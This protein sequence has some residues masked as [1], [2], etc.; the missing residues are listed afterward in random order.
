M[1]PKKRGRKRKAVE[2]TSD[3]VDFEET[4]YTWK[5]PINNPLTFFKMVVA[6]GKYHFPTHHVHNAL[7]TPFIEH[8]PNSKLKGWVLGVRATHKI[9]GFYRLTI[10]DAETKA[11]TY[12]TRSD[13]WPDFQSTLRSMFKGDGF[14]YD[15]KRFIKKPPL[16]QQIL[17]VEFIMV[18]PPNKIVV[19]SADKHHSLSGDLQTVLHTGK[20]SDV[21]ILL[22]DGTRLTCHTLILFA[23]SNVLATMFN[24][25]F[26][27]SL[28][29]EV[30][31]VNWTPAVVRHFINFMY[32][33]YCTFNIDDAG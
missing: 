11:R 25:A 26:Q 9:N 28:D 19:T 16:E 20:N 32:T 8:W 12:H 15:F 5:Y 24:S 1:P 3:P 22:R 30:S 2:V 6:E 23:R 29:R 4:H 27:E 33:D 18:S 14:A 7:V 17:E 13:P 21:D 10:R 31:F